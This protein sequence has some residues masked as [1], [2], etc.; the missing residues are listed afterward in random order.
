MVI[1]IMSNFKTIPSVQVPLKKTYKILTFRNVFSEL[2][3]VKVALT[4]ALSRKV[5]CRSSV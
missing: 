2:R 1:L 3:E 4:P 5:I